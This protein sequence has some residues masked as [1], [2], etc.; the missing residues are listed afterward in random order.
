MHRLVLPHWY[1]L[2]TFPSFFTLFYFEG[3]DI[4]GIKFAIIWKIAFSALL[5]FYLLTK[6]SG[7]RIDRF[8]FFGYL[9]G[10]KNYFSLGVY[11]YILSASTEAL[12]SIIIPLIVHV[13]NIKRGGLEY[14]DRLYRAVIVL[15]V[16]IILSVIPFLFNLVNPISHGYNLNIFGVDA[17]GFI[18][19][20][21]TPHSASVTIGFALVVL[22]YHIQQ[23]NRF[24]KYI[25]GLLIIVGIWAVIYTYAR[26]GF[27]VLIV[28]SAY[29]ITRRRKLAFY[30]KLVPI[31]TIG[32]LIAWQIYLSSEI[33][34]MRLVGTNIYLEQSHMATDISVSSG[35]EVYGILAL[36]NLYD[37]GPLAWL[38]GFGVENAKNLMLDAI[39]IRIYAHNGFI[40]VLQFNGII[41]GILFFSF[42][43]YLTGYIR[44][45]KDSKYVTLT[46]A[47]FI[48]Y[49]IQMLFQG[50]HFFLPD[51][52]FAMSISFL[53]RPVVNRLLVENRY[54]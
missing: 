19:I 32:A 29:L 45:R 31:L 33:F 11:S 9:Y 37:A 30:L 50:E 46:W 52:I 49:L 51:L 27:V 24:L 23:Q 41:G 43:Y 16:Y 1:H 4:I 48:C 15:S 42:L 10:V 25:Y 36:N 28:A 18:G 8:V 40:D 13:L 7:R 21:Q 12:K 20:F 5:I 54:S 34:Q 47:L 17:E 2:L 3:I 14:D 53:G 38:V 39:G 22:I 35:R 44:K 26:L 6:L